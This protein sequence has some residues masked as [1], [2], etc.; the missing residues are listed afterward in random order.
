MVF[1]NLHCIHEYI[2]I[3]VDNAYLH[4]GGGSLTLAQLE[5]ARLRS[6]NYISIC[7]V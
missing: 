2:Y 5:G 7:T 1:C 3:Y 4:V 6:P